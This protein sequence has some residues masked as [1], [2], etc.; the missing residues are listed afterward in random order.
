[1]RTAPRHLSYFGDRFCC[2]AVIKTFRILFRDSDIG[3]IARDPEKQ[4]YLVNELQV[5]GRIAQNF[6]DQFGAL[7]NSPW[8]AVGAQAKLPEGADLL[9]ACE[10]VST[11]ADGLQEII[12][13]YESIGV[14]A[15]SQLRD[16]I[17]SIAHLPAPPN[18]E[19][20]ACF[21]GIDTARARISLDL[22]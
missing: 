13:S 16:L 1:M 2:S 15:L 5:F 9:R 10:R 3:T 19:K 17:V 4:K 11:T 20:I 22:L 6:C 14:H 7:S 18:L 8:S 21:S 12:Y